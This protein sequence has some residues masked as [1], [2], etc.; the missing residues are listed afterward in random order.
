LERDLGL[1]TLEDIVHYS[2]FRDDIYQRIVRDDRK[3]VIID[4]LV[5]WTHIRSFIKGSYNVV[6]YWNNRTD[7]DENN[8]DYFYIPKEVYV[9]DIEK[10][11]TEKRCRVNQATKTLIYESYFLNYQSIL[12]RESKWDAADRVMRIIKRIR[13]LG[14]QNCHAEKNGNRIELYRKQKLYVDGNVI[15]FITI[16]IYI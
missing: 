14:S 7:V 11:F 4:P 13:G 15:L 1:A 6:V 3:I 5:V 9:D 12:K 2:H 16:Y 8:R 10:Q